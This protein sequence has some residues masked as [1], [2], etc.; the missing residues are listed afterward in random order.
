M[1]DAR[2]LVLRGADRDEWV[3]PKGSVGGILRLETLF[4]ESA[5]LDA[6]GAQTVLTHAADREVAARAFALAQSE[7]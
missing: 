6:A 5:L 2:C 4:R 7:P 1:I 3:F